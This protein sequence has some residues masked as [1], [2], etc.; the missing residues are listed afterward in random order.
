M[1]NYKP[2]KKT[3]NQHVTANH[4]YILPIKYWHQQI[5]TLLRYQAARALSIR[6]LPSSSL[7]GNPYNLGDPVLHV[8]SVRCEPRLISSEV[9]RSAWWESISRSA[10]SG[11]PAV[12]ISRARGRTLRG[13]PGPV[14]LRGPFSEWPRPLS[15]RSRHH[16][17][18]EGDLSREP[19]RP[20]GRSVSPPS[21]G[22]PPRGS[23][24]AAAG[25]R[26]PACRHVRTGR[27][28]LRVPSVP[29]RP[30]SPSAPPPLRGRTRGAARRS[31]R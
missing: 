19:A 22:V 9:I 30:R 21:T 7:R 28:L 6:T 23:T 1:K 15:S 13:S 8:N 3:N 2:D 31:P 18:S 20:G 26:T 5:D 16:C 11:L 25:V 10:T 4:P 24:V 29:R 14:N 12:P 17:R 27:Q